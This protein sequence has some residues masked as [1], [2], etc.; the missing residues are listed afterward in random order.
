MRFAIIGVALALAVYA[1]IDCA[2]TPRD[3]AKHLPKWAWIILIILIPLAG[4][5]AWLLAGKNRTGGASQPPPPVVAPDDNP[6]FLRQLRDIDEEHESMLKDW[7]ENLRRREDELRDEDPS[8]R[9]DDPG[10]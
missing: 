1:A 7:E 6:E 3:R 4:P 5:A 10:T 2:Q 8:R 9:D